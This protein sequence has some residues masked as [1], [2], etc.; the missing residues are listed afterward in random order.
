MSVFRRCREILSV[1]L[2]I[3]PAA[4]TRDLL[5]KVAATGN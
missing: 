3:A 1:V 2:G 4:A 5:S